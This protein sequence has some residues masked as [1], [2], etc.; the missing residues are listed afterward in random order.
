MYIDKMDDYL[1]FIESC[2]LK[3]YDSSLVIHKHHIY[4]RSIYG[5]NKELVRLSVQ[6]HIKAHLLLSECF[7]HGSKEYS[8]NLKSAR[9]LNSK[10]IRD[11]ETLEKINSAYKGTNNPFY[12]KKHSEELIN[13][14]KKL[15]GE[16]T[17]GKSYDQLYENPLEQ[18]EKRSIGVSRYHKE[19]TPEQRQKRSENISK[20]LKNKNIIPWNKGLN[21]SISE[22]IANASKKIAESKR[23][24]S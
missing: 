21:S 1:S 6:D 23:K 2:R 11:K 12:G 7:V 20:S 8:D 19:M 22:K 24:K 15:S 16:R 9:L 14:I 10:S 18:K 5:E 17:R 13:K 4:P 3:E